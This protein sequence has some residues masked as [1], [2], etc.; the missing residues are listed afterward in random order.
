MT[1][2]KHKLIPK[3]KTIQDEQDFWDTHSVLDYPDQFQKIKMDF[4]ALKPSTKT[5][6]LRL[7]E[8][9]LDAI[10]ITANKMDFPYQSYIKT[11]LADRMKQEFA[12]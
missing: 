8:S 1:N 4:S 12:R 2:K 6:S 7:P 9:M 11:I 3:F 10:K 5:I